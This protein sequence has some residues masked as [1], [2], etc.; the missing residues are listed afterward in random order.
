[1]KKTVEEIVPILAELSEDANQWPFESNDRRKSAG[2]HQVDSNTSLQAQLDTMAREIIKLTLT[3]IQ[4]EPQKQRR[5]K[6]DKQFG[7]FL[8]VLKHLLVNIPF[9]EVLSQMPAY[10]KFLKK[11]LF[12][13]RKVKETSVVK[14]TKHCSAILQ[15]KL[16][17]KC[18]DTGSFTIS[19]SLGST[20]FEK[21]LCDSGAS[22]NLMPLS[23]LR[24]LK[25]EIREI[26]SIPMSLQLAD[27]IT[28]IR[29]GIVED[30]LVR[31]EHFVFLVDFI[32]VNMEENREVPLILGR[33]FLAT[34]R[35]ILDI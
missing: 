31:M 10:A 18:G 33:T 14:L 23:I 11:I 13:K 9:T 20:K 29:E 28:I 6:M 30:V 7:H 32:V 19:C 2:V 22:I 24:K 3:K 26:R 21:S 17:P 12:K 1:M 25:R 35:A 5:E 15:N 8:E 4:S 16:P 34:G 27:Q